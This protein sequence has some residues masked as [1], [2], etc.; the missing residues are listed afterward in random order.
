ML[1]LPSGNSI[2]NGSSGPDRADQNSNPAQTQLELDVD[3]SFIQ[4]N[5]SGMSSSDSKSY[6]LI[7]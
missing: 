3:V 1:S 6:T 2:A 7:T 5:P 4:V